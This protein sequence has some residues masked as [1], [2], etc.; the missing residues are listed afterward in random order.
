MHF[1]GFQDDLSLKISFNDFWLFI[2]DQLGDSRL[3]INRNAKTIHQFLAGSS[4][5]FPYLR[6]AIIQSYKRS[7]CH[8]LGAPINLISVLDIL[9]E[10]AYEL[11]GDQQ[12]DLLDIELLEEIAWHIGERF[13][14]T[15]RLQMQEIKTQESNLHNAEPFVK[16]NIKSAMQPAKIV[17]FSKARIRRS[18]SQL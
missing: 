13:K 8:H 15:I 14:A 7:Q 18:N 1:K 6:S 16:T 17:S 4:D 10:T 3:K 9:G 11:Q 5:H 12:D 2:G